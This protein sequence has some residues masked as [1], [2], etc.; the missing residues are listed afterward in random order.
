MGDIMRFQK[1]CFFICVIV[2][3][4]FCSGLFCAQAS[5]ANDIENHWAKKE[6]ETVLKLGIVKGYPDGNFRPD[7]AITKAE[8]V[9]MLVDA[10][11]VEPVPEGQQP[12]FKDVAPESWDYPA[13]ETAAAAGI[14]AGTG[15]PDS[16]FQPDQDITRAEMADLTGHLM[17]EEQVLTTGDIQQNNWLTVLE[18]EGILSGYPDGS[19]GEDNSLTRAEACVVILRLKDKLLGG[20]IDKE[21][22]WIASNQSQTGYLA[23]TE[24]DSD[25]KPYYGNLAEMAQTGQMEYF[26]GIRKYL[27]WYLSNLNSKDC[28]GLSGT[29][30]D[31]HLNDGVA[32]SVYA[33]DSA[34]SYAATL[35]S[36]A[37]SYCL[38]SGDVDFIQEHYHDLCTVSDVITTLQ[39]SDGLIWAKPNSNFKY[40][41]DN[42]EDYRGLKDWSHLLAVLG[43]KDQSAVCD[44]K[45]ELIRQGILKQ[46]WDEDTESFAW[47][48]DQDGEK[49][50]ASPSQAY[51]GVLCQI[52]PVTFGVITPT[53]TKAV[54]AYKELNADLPHWADLE[55]GDS[56]PW[57]ILGYTA[58]TMDDLSQADSF[59]KN[60]RSDYILKDHR[61]P[62]STFEDAYY[63]RA[64][65]ALQE[66]II[67][68]FN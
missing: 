44:E 30:Y 64:C 41:M 4:L 67:A 57:A 54:L 3:I 18:H 56:L 51:P 12:V 47:A 61:Y 55:V 19:L 33:Y 52:F 24:G 26:S 1:H 9:T 49:S 45:A 31:Q 58:V 23:M 50:L 8:F 17:A 42:C 66:I 48:V 37:S 16:Y 34:D 59:L 35:L 7:Q 2:S 29:I 38:S 53:D 62:W 14:I 22:Q 25:I 21:R 27:T 39:D 43:F 6:I 10:G 60:C 13:I 63:I 11:W 15:N 36:L 20:E 65:N 46:F 40:L 28:C 5:A 68:D 32:Q